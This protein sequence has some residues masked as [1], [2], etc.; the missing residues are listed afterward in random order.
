MCCGCVNKRIYLSYY[1]LNYMTRL[2]YNI[3]SQTLAYAHICIVS[4]GPDHLLN[5][6]IYKAML[7]LA[8]VNKGKIE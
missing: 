4:E 7:N 8:I 3:E 6:K 5:Y 1:L 2:M